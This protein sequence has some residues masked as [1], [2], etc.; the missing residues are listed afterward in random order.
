[1]RHEDIPEIN[2]PK[3]RFPVLEGDKLMKEVLN[4]GYNV[5]P[6][7]ARGLDTMLK[8][9]LSRNNRKNNYYRSSVYWKCVEEK[10][11]ENNRKEKTMNVKISKRLRIGGYE[12]ILE[13]SWKPFR[14]LQVLV[15]EI[16]HRSWDWIRGTRRE[17]Q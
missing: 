14:Y 10:R 11:E 9:K 15:K 8:E 5:H 2:N 16:L 3:I 6:V 13:F 7:P 4:G 17:L 1:M 12:H